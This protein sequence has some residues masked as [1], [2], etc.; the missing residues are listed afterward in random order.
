MSEVRSLVEG[1]GDA[2]VLVLEGH[3]PTLELGQ[4]VEVV[5]GE[6][7]AREDREVDLDLV[8]PARVDRQVDEEQLR[9]GVLSVVREGGDEGA[10]PDCSLN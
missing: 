5:G 6:R 4:V 2:L 1:L 7:L 10:E 9:P 8:E 3:D